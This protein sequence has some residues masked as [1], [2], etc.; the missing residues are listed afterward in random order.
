MDSMTLRRRVGLVATAL[1]ASLLLLSCGDDDGLGP[2]IPEPEIL[3]SRNGV[4]QVTL[5]QAPARVTVAGRSFTSNVFNGQYMP[6]VLKMQRGDRLELQLVNRIDKADIQIDGPQSTNLHYH[7]MVVPPVAPGDDVFL[8]VGAGA[9]YDYRWQVPRDHAQGPHWYHPHSHGLVEPQILSG[10]SGMLVIDGAVAQHY[11]AFSG[12]VERHL[13]LKDIVLP[14]ADPDAANTKTINGLLGG[15]L[16]LRPGEMQ[17]WNLGNLGADAYFDLAIDGV[18][19]WEI[20]RDGNVLIQPKLLS[21]V[22]LPPGSRSTVVVVAPLSIGQYP[23]RTLEVDTGP[24]GDPNPNVRLAQVVVSGTPQNTEALQARLLEP[25]DNQGTIGTTPA[26]VAALPITNRR[27]ITFSESEDGN[28]FYLAVDGSGPRE[29]DPSR[30]DIT[31]TLGAVE[32]WTLRNVSG[33]R[34]VFHIHQLDFLV[35]SINGQAQPPDVLRDVV[36]LPY[37]QNGVPGEVKVII[38]FTN[39]IMVGRFVYHCHIVGHEDAGMMANLVVLAPGQS[40]MA[41]ARMRTMLPRPQQDVFGWLAAL[42]GKKAVPEPSLWE[43]TICRPGETPSGNRRNV[44]A[45]GGLP[46]IGASLLR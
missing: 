22:Y 1:S 39:P 15:T 19:L 21:S 8:D 29:Y 37:A 20:N 44:R 5:T 33:E 13:L 26:E 23:V 12:L 41:P 34:H 24:Q 31:V 36:D 7:G 25:A 35:T 9:D 17:V 46:P 27:V 32:E 11:T 3:S 10:M 30:D 45:G 38:P 18:Q 16:R 28:T 14:G 2:E 43:E 4:L 40:A 42:T 6:P